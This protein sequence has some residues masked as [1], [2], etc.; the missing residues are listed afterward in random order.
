LN[1]KRSALPDAASAEVPEDKIRKYLLSTTHRSGKSKAAFF[2]RFGFTAQD[3]RQL[4]AALQRHAQENPVAE[5]ETTE[6]GVRYVI[7]G[8][9][10]A[11]DGTALNV[12]SVWFINRDAGAPRFATAHPL[13]RKTT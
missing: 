10:A 13:K 5:T 12:R 4:G 3:W 1:T 6:F 7:D 9:L 11:P 8:P 2:L